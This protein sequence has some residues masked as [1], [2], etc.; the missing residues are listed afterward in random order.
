MKKIVLLWIMII[1]CVVSGSCFAQADSKLKGMNVSKEQTEK[2][3]FSFKKEIGFIDEQEN[4]IKALVY[5]IQQ[6]LGTNKNKLDTLVTELSRMIKNKEDMSSIRKKLEEISK[7]QVDST[8]IDIENGRKIEGVLTS[9]QLKKWNA[10]KE[11]ET[12][13]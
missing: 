12:K 13:K 3:I 8:C 2:N 7:I 10:I 1:S 9:E 5:D 11:R 4:K 6:S